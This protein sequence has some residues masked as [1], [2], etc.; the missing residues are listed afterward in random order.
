MEAG[1]IRGLSSTQNVA[2]S[3]A[4]MKPGLIVTLV[5]VAALGITALAMHKT[6]VGDGLLGAALLG[7]GVSIMK[8]LVGVKSKEFEE[9]EGQK[10][11]A[12]D[13]EWLSGELQSFGLTNRP[14][15]D[16]KDIRLLQGVM[17]DRSTREAAAARIVG[18]YHASNFVDH[19]SRSYGH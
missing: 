17:A 1:I 8:Q 11:E 2:H 3:Q 10:D 14:N 9:A 18:D 16:M 4:S 7:G 5:A 19:I 12:A 6:G 13:R 15:A